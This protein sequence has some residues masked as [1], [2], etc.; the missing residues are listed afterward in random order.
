MTNIPL[1]KPQLKKGGVEVGVEVGVGVLEAVKE[2]RL[3]RAAAKP[4]ELAFNSILPVWLKDSELKLATPLAS[5][6]VVLPESEPVVV[7]GL[8][9][10]TDKIM[11]RPLSEVT[12][13]PN[14]SS[15]LT[16]VLKAEPVV[17]VDGG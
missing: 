5:F 9:G 8:T 16:E 13:L 17:K 7:V 1:C 6:T 2:I 11:L 14:W 10:T 12:T 4:V 15:T 3:L